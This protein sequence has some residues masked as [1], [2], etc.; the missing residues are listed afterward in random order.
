MLLALGALWGGSFFFGKLVAAELPP[1]TGM[2]GRVGF[3]A[4]ALLAACGALG[5]ALPRDGAAWRALI[6][7]GALNNVLPMSLILYAQ[8]E[9]ASGLAAILN[10][11][12]PI[13]AVLLA[14]A[15]TADERLT[16]ARLAG[17]LCGFAGV[18]VLVGPA[19]LRG[20]DDALLA[21]GASLAAAFSYACA[22]V[23]GRRLR[24]LSPAVAATGQLAGASLLALPLALAVDRPWTL[25]SPSAGGWAALAG[26]ALLCTALA[27]LLYF[28]ILRTAGATN[29]LL[30]TFL[31]PASAILL[32]WLFLDERLAAQHLAGFALI[33]LGLACLDGRPLAAL[34]PPRP[35]RP[36]G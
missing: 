15:T 1:L 32:G 27:Y 23:Y 34:R 36:P 4:L 10:A 26:L 33:G 21:A 17:V 19:A 2:L 9:L 8:T 22:G 35:A 30:V 24:P 7:M 20:L 3:A 31:I 11:A 6:V 14:H 25:A 12:T 13:F 28:R 29:L 16:G 5:V 18:A